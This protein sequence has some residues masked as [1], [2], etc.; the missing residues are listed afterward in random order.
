MDAAIAASSSTCTETSAITK[1]CA[2]GTPMP[3]IAKKVGKTQQSAKKKWDLVMD[4]M[5]PIG[6]IL[7]ALTV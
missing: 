2:C 6:S 4:I 5:I 3:F 7:R 1:Q